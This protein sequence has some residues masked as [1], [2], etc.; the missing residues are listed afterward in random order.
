MGGREGDAEERLLDLINSFVAL[1]PPLPWLERFCA[2]IDK[3]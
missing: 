3:P 1:R 2:A